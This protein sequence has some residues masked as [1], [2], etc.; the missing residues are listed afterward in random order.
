MRD[1]GKRISVVGHDG[2]ELTV[3]EMREDIRHTPLSGEPNILKGTRRYFLEDEISL[4]AW[5]DGNFSVDQTGELLLR[6]TP[7][8]EGA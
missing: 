4:T 6:A 7:P 8:E 3:I 5:S 2:R 1:T